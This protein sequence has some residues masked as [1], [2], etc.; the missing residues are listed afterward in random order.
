MAKEY[1]AYLS[2]A[3]FLIYGLF[4]VKP[5]FIGLGIIFLFIGLSDHLKQK[6]AG[7]RPLL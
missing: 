1:L 4:A 6:I 2:A 7:M 5:I 3:I